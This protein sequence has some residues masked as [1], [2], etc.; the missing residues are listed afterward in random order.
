MQPLIKVEHLN[1]IYNL[2]KSSEYRALN[3]INL[4]IYPEEF[5]IFFGPSGCGKSTLLYSISG[6]ETNTQGN[7]YIDGKNLTLFNKNELLTFHRKTIGMIFQAFYLIASL[8][9][10]K[11]VAL[12]QI[13][14]NSDKKARTKKALEMLEYFG[15]SK[16]ARKLPNELSGGQ[17]QRVAIS[18]AL[19]ND[20]TILMADE[21]VGNLD[22]KS[23]QDVMDMLKLLN[24]NE[25][26]TIILVTHNP[27]FLSYA[28]R[29]FYMKD[30]VITETRVNRHVHGVHI[31]TDDEVKPN[32]SREL[33]LLISTYSSLSPSQIGNLLIPFKAKQIVSE[34]LIGMTTEEVGKIEKKV[35]NLLMTGVYDN[36]STFE[37][38]DQSMEKGGADLDKRT[39]KKIA[40][41]I[42]D[43]IG[44]IKKIED[45]ENKIRLRISPNAGGEVMEVRHYLLDSYDIEVKNFIVLEVIDRAIKD[46]LD[47]VIDR[48]VFRKRLNAPLRRGGAGLNKRVAKKMS[49]RLELLILGKYK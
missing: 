32:I 5:I 28:H 22:S 8:T 47:N 34:A 44:E 45:E 12:P 24:E 18:R 41:K 13:F 14:M 10:Q 2:G 3:D 43:I 35:E 23:S 16:Q 37:F 30:G 36:D 29:V 19:M 27:A 21:P 9:V 7:I 39:A 40:D 4:E 31:A 42:K 26:K 17:Q 6:L 15:V 20:P 48:D 11:N 46:R 38:L 25:K 49:K 1:V 33:E